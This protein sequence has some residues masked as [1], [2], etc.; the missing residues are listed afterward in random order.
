M[1]ETL[2]CPVCGEAGC[3]QCRWSL[4]TDVNTEWRYDC[5]RCGR[6]IILEFLT[7]E[8]PGLSPHQRAV[9]SHRL[10]RQQRAGSAPP[11]I[12]RSDLPQV[13]DPL[14]TPAEQADNLI[15]WISRHQASSA[16]SA[17][18]SVPEVSAWIGTA[19]TRNDPSALKWLLDQD[20]VKS[21]VEGWARPGSQDYLFRLNLAGWQRYE[22][23]KHAQVESRKAF[24]AMQFGD[25]DSIGW[26]MTVSNRR[27]KPQVLSYVC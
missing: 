3:A 19:I 23:L 26:S 7:R 6:F 2:N 8:L 9:L 15:L 17:K 24:M 16:E 1:N 20:G 4:K 18:I 11:S 27:S 22:T 21:L 12:L 5:P 25:A 14:P 13:D 10:R